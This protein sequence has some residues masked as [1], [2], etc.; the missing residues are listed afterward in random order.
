MYNTTANL[1]RYIKI[2]GSR[3]SK[4]VN[5]NNKQYPKKFTMGDRRIVDS[6]YSGRIPLLTRKILILF[7]CSIILLLMFSKLNNDNKSY[8]TA[9]FTMVTFF[10]ILIPFFFT[11]KKVYY[12]LLLYFIILVVLGSLGY[13]WGL[14][15]VLVNLNPLKKKNPNEKKNSV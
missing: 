11:M 12:L 2:Q 15:G 5:Y 14:V 8:V 3:D 9:F 10:L 6:R 7:I 1:E 13:G 4:E